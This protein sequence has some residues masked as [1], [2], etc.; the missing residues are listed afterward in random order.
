MIRLCQN[1]FLKLFILLALLFMFT[2]KTQALTSD[3]N[4]QLLDSLDRTLALRDLYQQ[5]REARITTLRQLLYKTSVPEKQKFVINEHLALEY[6]AYI[7]DSALYFLSQNL[8]IAEKNQDNTKINE[9]KLQLAHILSLSGMYLEAV[10]IL[11]S[12]NRS[13]VSGTMLQ[14]YYYVKSVVFNELTQY[15][16]YNRFKTLYVS[17]AKIYRDSLCLIADTNSDMYLMT[18]EGRLRGE[19]NYKKAL[20]INDRRLS[21]TSVNAPEYAIVT[22]YRALIY[23]KMGDAEGYKKNL[24]LSAMTDIRGAIKD[25]T[26]LRLLA[27]KLFD[28]GDINRASRYIQY[29]MEDAKF[30]N[31]KLRSVQLSATLPIITQAFHNK[32]THQ[33]NNL[34]FL[35]ILI[36]VLLLVLMSVVFY[37]FKQKRKLEESRN[38]LQTTNAQL[39][40][41]TKDLDQMNQQLQKVNQEVI[42][43]NYIK[44][45]YIARFL[46]MSSSYLNRIEGLSWAIKKKARD[47]DKQSDLARTG[48]MTKNELN[49]FYENFDNSFLTIYPTFIEEFNKLLTEDGQIVVENVGDKKVLNSELRVFALI[50]LGFQDSATIAKMLRYS[51]NTIYNVKAQVKNK[52]KVSRQDFELLVKKIGSFNN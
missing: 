30:Y 15:T 34:K 36:S 31:A 12:I 50:R 48:S 26:S 17:N 11:N 23:Q 37:V 41:L 44:E 10:D 3:E 4:M 13:T 19:K 24:I 6:K 38:T 9:I 47:G 43:A 35:I 33:I 21:Q 29:C 1:T 5:K 40:Q 52:A 2:P 32:S 25:N 22:F 45:S 7:C 39:N 42:E 14:Q 27:N 20:R 51:V 8:D 46:S 16:R 49:E 18:V 28:E